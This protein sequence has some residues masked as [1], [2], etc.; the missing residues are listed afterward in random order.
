[1]STNLG[2]DLRQAVLLNFICFGAG[3]LTG[4]GV[5]STAMSAH[6]PRWMVWTSTALLGLAVALL[7]LTFA[8]AWRAIRAMEARSREEQTRREQGRG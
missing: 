8:S 2:R 7:G 3:V 1:V 6:L 4:L 5:H